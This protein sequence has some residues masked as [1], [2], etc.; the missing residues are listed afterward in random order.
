MKRVTFWATGVLCAGHAI[1]VAAVDFAREILPILSNKCFVCHG[2]D[3]KDKDLPRLDSFAGATR[4]IDGHRAVDPK[5][6]KPF[7]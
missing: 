5:S 3:A 1:S 2:P 6:P 4:D 7:P